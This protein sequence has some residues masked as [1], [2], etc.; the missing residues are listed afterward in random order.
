MYSS[1]SDAGHPSI[2]PSAC[3]FAA[4]DGEEPTGD[5]AEQQLEQEAGAAA[6][7]AAGDEGRR[8]QAKDGHAGGRTQVC[9]RTAELYLQPVQR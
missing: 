8:S 9:R 3:G 6:A 1:S 2:H 7:G 5:D 4:G